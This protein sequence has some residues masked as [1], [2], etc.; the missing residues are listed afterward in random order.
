[1][2]DE[3]VTPVFDCGDMEVDV[4]CPVFPQPTLTFYFDL[5]EWLDIKKETTLNLND[6]YQAGHYRFDTTRH[7]YLNLPSGFSGKLILEVGGYDPL[8]RSLTHQVI[9]MHNSNWVMMRT[10][11]LE[12][13]NI[14]CGTGDDT[15]DW[16][17]WVTLWSSES[18]NPGN[19]Q[20]KGDYIEN[21]GTADWVN[22]TYGVRVGGNA[23]VYNTN[24]GG[25]LTFLSGRANFNQPLS[26]AGIGK[27]SGDVIAY[28]ST[29]TK[30][31][32]ISTKFIE[33]RTTDIEN[34]K[35][36]IQALIDGVPA[37]TPK[38]PAATDISLLDLFNRQTQLSYDYNNLLILIQNGI[39][40][41][42]E[43]PLTNTGGNMYAFTNLDLSAYPGWNWLILKCPKLSGGR[44]DDFDEIEID[45]AKGVS[46][47]A[48]RRN[49]DEIFEHNTYASGSHLVYSI[50]DGK[51]SLLAGN[52]YAPM[53]KVGAG[54]VT[55]LLYKPK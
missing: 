1:M 43:I 44:G 54:T 7:T 26:V 45:Y 30:A 24:T 17:G 47:Y 6:V 2:A 40:K 23:G 31:T 8:H 29:L 50:A 51:V 46:G 16:T 12:N 25:A 35:S 55:F 34:M 18:F 14:D 38:A 19:Y 53:Q 22:F 10:Q 11:R 4:E 5:D 42:V 32:D 39:L 13:K 36:Q 37:P 15:E 49:F 33:D 41:I 20:P 48:Y 27:F 52:G 21:K 9:K 28:A 3:K